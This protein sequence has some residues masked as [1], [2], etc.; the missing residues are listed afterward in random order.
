LL[1]IN[2]YGSLHLTPES[3]TQR[4]KVICTIANEKIMKKR[5]IVKKVRNN[6]EFEIGYW[7]NASSGKY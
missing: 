1:H 2:Y 3:L 6:K 5:V 7:N 4:W